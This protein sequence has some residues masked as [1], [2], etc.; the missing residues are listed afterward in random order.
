MDKKISIAI[1]YHGRAEF[2]KETLNSLLVQT[3]KNFEVVISDDSN[4]KSDILALKELADDYIKR[5]LDIN[6]IRTN[7]NLGAI[8][9]TKQAV[10]HCKNDIIRILHTDDILTPGTIELELKIFNE[11]PETFFAFHD[12]SVFRKHFIPNEHGKWSKTSWVENW[13]IN[14]NYTHSILPSCL[15]F[16]KSVLQEVGFFNPEFEFMYDWEYQIRLFEYAFVNNKL[17]V[18]IEPGY[19][20]WR[21]SKKS[22]SY[23]KSLVCYND[24]IRIAKL[25]EES[26]ER[27]SKYIKIPFVKEKIKFF[28]NGFKNRLQ[29]EYIFTNH[30]FELPLKFRL[31][32]SLKRISNKIFSLN[33]TP[34]R[35]ILTILGGIKIKYLRKKS[36][37]LSKIRKSLPKA[38]VPITFDNS[39]MY[40]TKLPVYAKDVTQKCSYFNGP[41]VGLIIQGQI[42]K[43]NNFTYETILM[44]KKMLENQNVEIILST[45]TDE[46]EN[47]IKLF[48]ELDIHVVLSDKIEYSGRGNVN[49]QI[50]TTQQGITKAESLNCEYVLKTRTDQRFYKTDVIEFFI[51]LQKQFPIAGSTKLQ[52]RIIACSFNSFIYRLYGVSDMFLFGATQDM[53]MYWNVSFDNHSPVEWKDKTPLELFKTYCPETYIARQFLVNIGHNPTEELYDSLYTYANYF[54]FI[55]KESLKLYW[56]KYSNMNSRWDFY[57]DSPMEECSFIDWFNLYSNNNKFKIYCEKTFKE[58]PQF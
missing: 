38:L 37:Y 31:K 34:E 1:P 40:Y 33:K 2:F 3:S 52:N 30:K 18:E 55:D 32:N 10:E 7:P 50:I 22:E 27:L 21:M 6:L 26:S 45:W 43:Q 47:I 12:A 23:N 28:R 53:K 8:K 15:I 41:K 4:N 14:K 9:N 49:Y 57:Y 25:L 29:N 48:E 20:G 54:I 5:G 36:R 44:Y 13:L 35:N 19:V 11:N 17:V 16:R 58:L 51:N 46:D 39:F 24:S 42:I 56:P